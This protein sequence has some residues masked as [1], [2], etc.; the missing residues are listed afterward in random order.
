[1]WSGGPFSIIRMMAFKTVGICLSDI[2][3]DIPCLPDGSAMN[4]QI[5]PMA[6]SGNKKNQPG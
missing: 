2:R 1:M 6:A 3:M 4:A 5:G